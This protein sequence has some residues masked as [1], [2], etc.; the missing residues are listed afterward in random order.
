[1]T[2]TT[3]DPEM[4]KPAPIGT[5]ERLELIDILRGFA[6]FG[7]FF[8]NVHVWFTGRIFLPADT[9]ADILKNPANA[10]IDVFE[11]YFTG[12]KF[13][14]IFSF[15]FGLGLAV[16]FERAQKRGQSPTH[17]YLRR[18]SSMLLIALA[19]LFLIWY[20]DILHIYALAG[21]FVLWFAARSPRTAAIWG[22]LLTLGSGLTVKWMTT[23]IPQLQSSP[24]ESA[25]AVALTEKTNSW[26]LALFATGSWSD[27][28][29]ANAV[30]YWVRFVNLSAFGFFFEVL[31]RILL[32]YYAGRI[33]LFRD[34]QA[35]KQTFRVLLVGGLLCGVLAEA[36]RQSLEGGKNALL[37][38]V[39]RLLWHL[40]TVGIAAL[41]IAALSLLFTR[42]WWQT[43][44]GVFAPAGRMALTNYLSQ[45]VLAIFIFY[46]VG[47]GWLG[48]VNPLTTLWVPVGIF[49]LQMIGSHFWLRNF[50]FGPVEWLWR[51]LTY[52]RRQPMR[53]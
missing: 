49:T 39:L 43:K 20:G 34:V 10:V 2:E 48:Q 14:T 35:K 30:G 46:G 37:P 5:S 19:H 11:R 13:V 9:R 26:M 53:R 7:V 32:G 18:G 15:L 16:Q 38:G 6:L 33:G 21:F 28:I 1:M 22:V 51:S 47:L 52:G 29:R 23:F 27:I 50:R 42:A 41:Y 4:A 24:A 17:F 3:V 36:L 31:G 44:L 45:S 40:H 8:S 12:G 25:A